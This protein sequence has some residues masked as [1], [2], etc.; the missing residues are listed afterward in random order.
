MIVAQYTNGTTMTISHRRA[1]KVRAFAT[2]KAADIGSAYATTPAVLSCAY[3]NPTESTITKNAAIQ[4]L[5]PCVRRKAATMSAKLTGITI[6]KYEDSTFTAPETAAT[7]GKNGTS[8]GPLYPRMSTPLSL[9][10]SPRKANRAG[11]EMILG[12][13]QCADTGGARRGG[14]GRSPNIAGPGGPARTR[15]SAPRRSGAGSKSAAAGK[16]LE[17]FD[18]F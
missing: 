8:L 18:G 2:R 6:S 4:Y 15:A 11:H 5:D 9:R 13:L 1:R 3:S 7:D 10:Y 16:L 17:S 14:R 12:C